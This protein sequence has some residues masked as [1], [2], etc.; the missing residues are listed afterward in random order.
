MPGP[1]V[2]HR[3]FN[4]LPTLFRRDRDVTLCRVVMVADDVVDQVANRF[5]RLRSNAKCRLDASI[6]RASAYSLMKL[7]S[8]WIPR[9]RGRCAIAVPHFEASMAGKS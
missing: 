5:T 4:E 3:K 8:W 7:A 2:R 1:F 9:R 6:K